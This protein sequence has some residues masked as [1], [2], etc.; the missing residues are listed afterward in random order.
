MLPGRRDPPRGV[1][2]HPTHPS[3]QG[4][5]ADH[6]PLGP[7]GPGR[8]WPP[9]PRSGV[10]PAGSPPP[11]GQ[12]PVPGGHPAPSHDSAVVAPPWDR[13]TPG[14]NH[15]TFLGPAL[16]LLVSK[17]GHAGRSG[18]RR[19]GSEASGLGGRAGR[20]AATGTRQPQLQTWPRPRPPGPK[21]GAL[22]PPPRASP[23]E[24]T[25]LRRGE[26][27]GVCVLEKDARRWSSD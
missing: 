10:S 8:L 12:R 18:G 9:G 5:R 22:T 2:T 3:L 11:P 6:S 23:V 7:L 13:A 27:G 1:R 14:R 4:R 15:G 24:E 25:G 16:L 21:V 19:P 20:T 26:L 17:G